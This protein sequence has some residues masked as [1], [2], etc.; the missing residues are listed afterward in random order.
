MI[1]RGAG[2]GTFPT[3]T[4]L[5]VEGGARR[6][7]VEDLN[8]DGRPDLVL[9]D[10]RFEKLAGYLNDGAGQFTRTWQQREF[11]T[12]ALGTGDFD[13]DGRADLVAAYYVYSQQGYLTILR[14]NGDG[15]FV[16]RRGYQA[17][18][19]SRS[20]TLADFNLDGHQDVAVATG[21]SEPES[22]S[23]LFGVGDGTF[24]PGGRLGSAADA[25]LVASGDFNGDGRP[26]LIS[27]DHW[28]KEVSVYLGYGDG[29]FRSLPSFA[30]MGRPVSFLVVDLDGDGADEV[31][32]IEPSIDQYGQLGRALVLRSRGDGTF[33][34]LDHFG[35]P[36]LTTAGAVG[37]FNADGRMD[38]VVLAGFLR[39]YLGDGSG[40]FNHVAAGSYPVY[41]DGYNQISVADMTGDGHE[42]IVLGA[43]LIYPGNG[44][45]TFGNALGTGYGGRMG[46]AVGDFDLDGIQDLVDAG[47]P[48]LALL[49]G[50]G[51]GAFWP[52][53]WFLA[54]EWSE[55][56]WAVAADLNGDGR[57]D[58]ITTS[59]G[60]S[61]ITVIPNIGPYGDLDEDGVNDGEDGCVDADGDGFGLPNFPASE[62]LADN[63]RSV[64]NPA[65][66]DSDSDGMGDA[67][68]PCPLD[69]GG[70]P[71]GDGV[72]GAADN[73]PRLRA[74]ETTD[75]DGDGLGDACDNCDRTANPDQVDGNGDGSGDACQPVLQFNSVSEDG[76]Q[77][78]EV[79]ASARDPQRDP[80]AGSV[81]FLL[82]QTLAIPN[83]VH[84]QDLC[85][86]GMFGARPGEGIVYVY[87][88]GFGAYLADLNAVT[89]CGDG[90]PDFWFAAGACAHPTSEF[91]LDTLTLQGVALPASFCLA[92]YR[93]LDPYLD[94]T[95]LRFDEQSLDLLIGEDLSLSIPF[96]SDLPEISD[97][98]SLEPGRRYRMQI[99][100][101]DGTSLPV[102]ASMSFLHQTESILQIRGLDTDQDGIADDKDD[103]TDTDGDG[104]GNPG[105]PVNT[106]PADNCPAVANP[107]QED[108]DA[109][110]LGDVCD[111]CPMDASNDQ[112][113]DGVCGAV[114]NCPAHANPE[115]ADF[116]QDGVGD[117]CDSCT[118]GDR[119]GYGDSGY[120]ANTCVR[121]NCAAIPNPSQED[122]DLDRVGDA[123]DNCPAMVNSNQADADHDGTG[124]D[125]D[126]CTDLDGDGF[127]N[128][129]FAANT[130]A[131]DNCPSTL[132]PGQENLDHDV[133]GDA[134]D[135]CTDPDADGFGSP[136]FPFST[137][138][139]DN[140]P[141]AF[142]PQQVD[143][144]ADHTGDD[145][146]PCADPDADG[147]GTPGYP[148]NT[149]PLD[150]CPAVFDPLQA[151][152]DHDGAGDA[153]DVCVDS[154]GD[155]FG[156]PGPYH[157]NVCAIDNCPGVAN[158]QQQNADFDAMGDVCDP[159]P[160]DRFNDLDGDGACADADNCPER[161][162]PEQED[163]DGDGP[164]D[165]CDN[166]PA[167]DNASQLDSDS[168]GA[169]DVCDNCLISSN[170][171][172]ADTDGD[173]HGDACD[174]CPTAA[175]HDQEDSNQD[176]SGDA[177]QPAI[178]IL[179]IQQGG[180]GQDLRVVTQVD[181]PQQDPL[182]GTVEILFKGTRTIVLRDM[183]AAP[184]CA[185]GF[186][187]DDIP[188]E[189]LGFI[190]D[191]LGEPILFDL[192]ANLAC[193]D[194]VQDFAIALGTCDNPSDSGD[195]L[196]LSGMVTPFSLCVRR[197]GTSGHELEMTVLD[198]SPDGLTARVEGS[199]SVFRM[200]FESGIPEAVNMPALLEDQPYRLVITVTDGATVPVAA[201]GA[202]EYHGESRL[203]IVGPNSPPSAQIAIAT[204]TVEC[205]GGA[206]GAVTLDASS[207][208]DP[209]STPG[210]SDD[211]VAYEWFEDPGLPTQRALGS[212]SILGVTLSLGTHTIGLRVT[213]SQG[214]T[215]AAETVITVRDTTPP[216]LAC[217]APATAECT[218][219]E[220][221]QVQVVATAT[222]ACSPTVTVASSRN[223][224][225]DASGTYPIGS[226][227][228]T[229]TAADEAG[230]V[231]TCDTSVTVRDTTAPTL[232]LAVDPDVLW[233]PN[234]R[235]VP[236]HLAW[237]ASDRCDSSASARLVSVSS[238]EPDDAPD[239]GDGR[240]T[241][242]TA[243]AETGSPDT[244]ILLRAE[245][246]GGGSGRTYE[247]TCTAS[248]AAGNSTSA[249]AIVRV[250]HDLG[251]GPEPVQV[252]V[253][254]DA[255]PGAAHLYWNTVAG[256][257]GYDVIWG[258]VGNLKV[259]GGRITLGAVRVMARLTTQ[260]SWV[261][262]AASTDGT[263]GAVP[264]GG[265]A[266]FY[267]VQYRDARGTSGY[268]SE[269]VPLP[270]EPAS[271]EGGCPGEEAAPL[272]GAS[273]RPVRR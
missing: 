114:D 109:D 44:D 173:G 267:L 12:G 118:D 176:G 251:E 103:C 96:E 271:C 105:F 233:P 58:A 181:D 57:L 203:V 182:S 151:D 15:T 52:P 194:S 245:R 123:C 272:S 265:R 190:S 232:T 172:Q 25:T 24:A 113:G 117:S 221:A 165:A 155:T 59:I 53:V 253:E 99:T 146:D 159:C 225:A 45:G 33:D 161:F 154:D 83:A 188:G 205:T 28:S 215:G 2:D 247:S 18:S 73:C 266:F 74:D 81:D 216:A 199:L 94:L 210:T 220:G 93:S 64:A 68:D 213:D 65:Q 1:L 186:L 252:G 218:G 41:S 7:L 76:G 51:L 268:G 104:L 101:G 61:E 48:Y 79:T 264:E 95:I 38:L 55:A 87:L 40:S 92:Q 110:G 3:W 30:S 135:P 106:C 193:N 153:C 209:D 164:G 125:C 246:S 222:D 187:L 82:E 231:A 9:Q 259:D 37:D 219:P 72:C 200:A 63:C 179:G 236:V 111:Q 11:S 97:I 36:S 260:N 10:K 240:T 178:A 27:A 136:G 185:A 141:D 13:G 134:C 130:C 34:R 249:L 89:E 77:V 22:I 230:N 39:L 192:D 139:L 21:G 133:P 149:C 150:D 43:S 195:Y 152:I 237:Q 167:A 166:C 138:A 14:G 241:G 255:M 261:E 170:T 54:P 248:D 126:P 148:S 98:S 273:D 177:C 180:T 168:D 137:C 70:D 196:P 262:G 217:P 69:S 85:N 119:D 234:H 144:D 132:N 122:S 239:D 50:R 207:S 142:N 35:I 66:G 128:P 8:R 140:C 183:S 19:N 78:L 112:D 270:R 206:G 4:T 212:G 20:I 163:I 250:P 204:P 243:G 6:M 131:V 175:N 26:D 184:D 29:T 115:Q 116:D 80:L 169:G 208:T 201:E 160:R 214:A 263:A 129:G 23:L 91:R 226:T 202:F 67:C 5:E 228:V 162:N 62:C 191:F 100:V 88:E 108:A 32:V 147:Y 198:M 84:A 49:R 127:G 75:T 143:T 254:P 257:L 158:P 107:G 102:T 47:F 56:S 223:G 258:D 42:D 86:A 269:S 90:W 189:G 60:G 157:N 17:G 256:A 145:C 235:L 224:G 242:D 229:F 16:S 120:A 171:S 197:V 124:D 121:D 244:E 31:V 227:V 156:D 238:S 46:A 174:N 71:D 211:I